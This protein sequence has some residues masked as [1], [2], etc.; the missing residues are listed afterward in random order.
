MDADRKNVFHDVEDRKISEFKRD[1]EGVVSDIKHFVTGFAAFNKAMPDESQHIFRQVIIQ[2]A[3]IGTVPRQDYL[4]GDAGL[5]PIWKFETS[6][7]TVSKRIFHPGRGERLT[8]ADFFISKEVSRVTRGVTAVQTKRNRA[9]DF[10]EFGERDINQLARFR[11]Y[12][13]SAYYLMVDE[14][15]KPPLD[16][17]LMVSEIEELLARSSGETYPG[18]PRHHS[19]VSQILRIPN[20]EVRQCCRGS[21]VFYEPFYSCRRGSQCDRDRVSQLALRYAEESNRIVIELRSRY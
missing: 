15:V 19:G 1:N 21:R 9:K 7:V 4:Q 2:A 16:C 3:Q 14:N 13:R 17:F 6:G 8:G 18:R 11:Q 10:F 12:W 5:E 20:S